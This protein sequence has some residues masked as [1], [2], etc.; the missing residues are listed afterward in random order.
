MCIASHNIDWTGRDIRIPR[1]DMGL[2]PEGLG[3]NKVRVVNGG[4]SRAVPATI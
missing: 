2:S 3:K 4:A 1:R